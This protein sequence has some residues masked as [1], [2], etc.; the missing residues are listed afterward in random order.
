MSKPQDLIFDGKKINETELGWDTLA[1]AAEFGDGLFETMMWQGGKVWHWAF[2]QHRL[3]RGCR[4]L[5]LEAAQLPEEEVLTEA[6]RTLLGNSPEPRLLKLVVFR[7]NKGNGYTP[8]GRDIH[9]LL[10]E[11]RLVIPPLSGLRL[12][13][14][15]DNAIQSRTLSSIKTLSSVPYVLASIEKRHSGYDELILIN[16]NGQLTETVTA[17]LFWKR[18]ETVFTPR[19]DCGCLDGTMRAATLEYLSAM[20]IKV[21][22]GHYGTSELL[23]AQTVFL[24]KATGI[25]QVF[26]IGNTLFPSTSE[27]QKLLRAMT[28]ELAPWQLVD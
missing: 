22:E 6:T 16:D 20:G 4:L 14:S 7:Q 13:F 8:E 25:S 9:W 24:T 1:R 27:D 12:G 26:A 10:R 23:K 15:K 18:G 17:N 3:S 21:S 28:A 5:D 11:R 19:I 2:H